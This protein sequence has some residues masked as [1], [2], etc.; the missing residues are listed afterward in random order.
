MSV[1]GPKAAM[2]QSMANQWSQPNFKPWNTHRE[3]VLARQPKT[4]NPTRVTFKVNRKSV[5]RATRDGL[6][7]DT[8]KVATPRDTKK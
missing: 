6:M 1:P 5:E 3:V 8:K 7:R 2:M 4:E